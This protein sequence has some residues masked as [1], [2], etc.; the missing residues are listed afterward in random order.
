MNEDKEWVCAACGAS[1]MGPFQPKIDLTQVS[2]SEQYE[3]EPLEVSACAWICAGC[4]LVH[5]Y[6]ED[7][8]LED[9]VTS[10]LDREMLVPQPDASYQRRS[11]MLRM[12]RRIKRM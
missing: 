3:S 8:D 4:G 6:I 11:Q 5:W 10:V 7:K 12:L 2:A 9:L 1:L